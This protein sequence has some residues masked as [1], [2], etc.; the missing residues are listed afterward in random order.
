MVWNNQEN[1]WSKDGRI[2]EIQERTSTLKF[3]KQ[4]KDKEKLASS[5]IRI[6][7]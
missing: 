4:V 3:K 5:K 1:C 2:M 7:S 6:E